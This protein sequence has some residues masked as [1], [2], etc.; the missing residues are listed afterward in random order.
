VLNA[1]S[2]PINGSISGTSATPL[3]VS[4]SA[5]TGTR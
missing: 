4:V 1:I 2:T 3:N 5:R